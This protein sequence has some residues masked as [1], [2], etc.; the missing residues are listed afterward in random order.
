[1]SKDKGPDI[2]IVRELIEDSGTAERSV[3]A[4]DEQSTE[5]KVYVSFDD[6]LGY[7]RLFGSVCEVSQN[8]RKNGYAQLARDAVEHP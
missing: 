3:Y 1:M 8:D 7:V 2:K 6:I 4:V 5:K